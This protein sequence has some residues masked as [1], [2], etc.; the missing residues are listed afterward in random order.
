MKKKIAIAVDGSVHCT[1][2]LRYA[3]ALA[4]TLPNLHYVLLSIQPAV[5]Q[6]L[7]HEAESNPQTGRALERLMLANKTNSR[8]VLEKARD[9]LI[10]N[11]IL[12]DCIE[13]QTRVRTHGV[14]QDLLQVCQ[15]A[16]YDALV[17]GRRGLGR[18]Q[19]LI[20]GSV[21]ANLLA[22]SQLT[23]IWMVDGEVRNSNILLAADGSPNALRALDHLA[24]M[25]GGNPRATLHLVH[26]K[27]K[28]QDIC[29]IDLDPETMAVTEEALLAGSQRRI[30]QFL[31]QAKRILLKNGLNEDQLQIRAVESRFAIAGTILDAARQGGFSTIVVG[32]SSA[33]K[34]LFVGSVARKIV[35]K[36]DHMSVW[37]V[38]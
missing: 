35:Q 36:A 18:M 27:P 14:A 15:T 25:L 32:K 5:S 11:G 30:D 2:A 9:Q 10:Q 37:W 22:H 20:T 24:F 29:T 31:P 33:P 12:P 16:P 28:L 3:A 26:V 8:Q 19:E 21:T 38:P 6:Y 23:P 17:V 1:H 7:S 34:S 13:M 4:P